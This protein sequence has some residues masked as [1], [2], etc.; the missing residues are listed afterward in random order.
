MKLLTAVQM[1]ELDRQAMEDIGIPG[2][3]LMENAVDTNTAPTMPLS[4]P[5]EIRLIKLLARFPETVRRSA[6]QLAPHMVT[7]YLMD[8]AGA[9]HAFYNKHRVLSDDP[10]MT[11]SRV[12]LIVAIQQVLRNGL[13]LLGVSAPESM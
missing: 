1:R 12:R 4:Q 11:V 8:L 7:F 10:D 13:T 3:A 6:T 9:F 5:N 2:V